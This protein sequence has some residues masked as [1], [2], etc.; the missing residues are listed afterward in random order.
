MTIKIMKI[1]DENLKPKATFKFYS[2]E[3]LRNENTQFS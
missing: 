1:I 2:L 3:N